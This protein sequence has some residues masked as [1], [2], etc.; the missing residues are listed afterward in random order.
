MLNE[1]RCLSF[2]QTVQQPGLGL[3]Y[4]LGPCDYATPHPASAPNIG[5]SVCI[6]LRALALLLQ[7]ATFDRFASF[8]LTFRNQGYSETTAINDT[9]KTKFERH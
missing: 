3:G 6:I 9:V 2:S 7:I 8:C 5:I 1:Q 4:Q